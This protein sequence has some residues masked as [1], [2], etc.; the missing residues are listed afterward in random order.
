[1][2]V[3]VTG[4]AGYLGSHVVLALLESGHEVDV[5]DDFS[6]G[7]PASLARAEIT[8]G[9]RVGTHT[10]DVADI[11]AMER[12]FACSDVDAVVHLA[13]LRSA[14][15]S[16]HRPL[17]AYETNL[18]TLFTLLRCMT[19][20][21]VG[22]L[23]LSSTAAVY[24]TVDDA[25][26]RL[27]EDRALAP[28]SPLG[29]TLATGEHVLQDVAG[30]G[31]ALR[32]AVVRC[33]TTVG[34]HSSGRLGEDRTGAPPSLLTRIGDVALGRREHL[35]V[36]DGLG[37]PDG[38]AVRDYVHVTDVAAGHVAALASLD[39]P[40]GRAVQAWNLGTGQATSVL[41]VLSTFQEVTGHCVPHRRRPAPPGTTA[42]AVADTERTTASLGWT[43]TRDL[44]EICR[45]HW[46]WQEQ[47]PRGYPSTL[48]PETPWRG[49]VGHRLRLVP[50]LSAAVSPLMPATRHGLTAR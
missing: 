32:A 23:V 35:E 38:T 36:F 16:V 24:G 44:A 41:D 34:A 45:D 37:T 2:R 12:V 26:T 6:R 11:D 8:S 20:Y 5:V 25:G 46:R 19:W 33:F 47:H 18:T 48:T 30:A 31:A 13:G 42:G 49:G 4:G 50:P 39:E 21:G 3:L 17:D 14:T 22:R 29:R 10:A 27:T 40:S 43:A 28:A 7:T 9:R 15:E 1:M